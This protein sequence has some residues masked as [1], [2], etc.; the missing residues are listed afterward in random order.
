MTSPDWRDVPLLTALS[1]GVQSVEADVW[2]INGTLFV[3]TTKS[4][5]FEILRCFQV[6]HERAALTPS[7][8]LASLYIQPL[9]EILNG[10]NPKNEFT[11]N[12]TT[13]KSGQFASIHPSYS[14]NLSQWRVRY[15]KQCFAAVLD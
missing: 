11:S 4:T 13:V 1:F 10:Q 12:L 2:L 9:L 15:F 3:S 8:T 14:S 5:T 6:G 7:R